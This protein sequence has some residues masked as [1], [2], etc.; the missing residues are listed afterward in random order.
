MSFTVKLRV[1]LHGKR[2]SGGILVYQAVTGGQR[3]RNLYPDELDGD[4]YAETD[5][6]EDWRGEEVDVFC[7]TD[8][9]NS[10]EPAYVH[11]ITLRPGPVQELSVEPYARGRWIGR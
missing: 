1:Y 11:R 10:G 6:H 8:G 3:G 7:H 9:I 5:W 4:G 2:V